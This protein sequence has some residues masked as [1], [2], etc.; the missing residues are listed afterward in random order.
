[1]KCEGNELEIMGVIRPAGPRVAGLNPRKM[2]ANTTSV[3]GIDATQAGK[4]DLP[5]QFGLAVVSASGCERK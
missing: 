3:E 5:Q 4:P 2:L 1:M